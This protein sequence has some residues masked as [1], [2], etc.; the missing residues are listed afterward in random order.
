MGWFNAT[1]GLAI[2]LE[3]IALVLI[4]IWD[5]LDSHADHKQT[6]AQMKIAQEQAAT[7]QAVAQSTINAERAWVLADL[8]V[9]ASESLHVVQHTSTTR[10]GN[11][12]SMGAQIMLTCKNEGRTPAWIDAIYAHMEIVAQHSH[13]NGPGN[14]SDGRTLETMGP[15]GA[16]KTGLRLLDL[17]C[18][19]RQKES[20]VLS[21]YVLV[22]Y[23]DIFDVK[24]ETHLGYS[25]F[26]SKNIYQQQNAPERNRNT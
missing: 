24:R 23:R 25:I 21:V 3:A 9:D 15:L 19:G 14:R 4:F 26:D 11:I 2:W 5:R 18:A 10:D 6:I 7:S 13:V 17:T 8:G 22:Q 16:G 1:E 12:E 20:D